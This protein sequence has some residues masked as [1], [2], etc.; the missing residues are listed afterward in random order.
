[1]LARRGGCQRETAVAAAAVKTLSGSV[2]RTPRAGDTEA[3]ERT[4]ATAAAA[5]IRG[6]AHVQQ[7]SPETSSA[8]QLCT[9]HKSAS[10]NTAFKYQKSTQQ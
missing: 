8:R 6:R 7:Q 1:M 3:T 9:I 4:H 10:V 2:G 5:A